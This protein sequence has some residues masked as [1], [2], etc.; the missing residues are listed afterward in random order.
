MMLTLNQILW[1]DENKEHRKC[2]KCSMQAKDEKSQHFVRANFK[3]SDHL[4][5]LETDKWII[6]LQ[7]ILEN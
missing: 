7:V 1:G 6:L 2:G 3:E 5:N 4:Q